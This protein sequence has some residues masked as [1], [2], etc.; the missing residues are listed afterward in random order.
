MNDHNVWQTYR[1]VSI[2]KQFMVRVCSQKNATPK[3]YVCFG[4]RWKYFQKKALSL[5]SN[6]HKRKGPTYA[7]K[8]LS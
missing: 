5:R 7:D 4:W 1:T 2:V 3:C 6:H 8:K